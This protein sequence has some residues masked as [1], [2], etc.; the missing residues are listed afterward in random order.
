MTI[1]ELKKELDKYP[2][3]YIVGFWD[4]DGEVIAVGFLNLSQAEDGDKVNM[5]NVKDLT[6]VVYLNDF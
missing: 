2:D 4:S 6:R 3:D 5:N 1:K